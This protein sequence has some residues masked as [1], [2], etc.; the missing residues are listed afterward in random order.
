MAVLPTA[1]HL[2]VITELGTLLVVDVRGIDMHTKRASV[3]EGE[4]DCRLATL[5]GHLMGDTFSGAFSGVFS[6]GAASCARNA[7]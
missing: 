1:L 7:L 2:A 5:Q 4:F 6:G 3:R